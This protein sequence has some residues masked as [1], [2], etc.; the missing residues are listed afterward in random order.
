VQLALVAFPA[1]I[2]TTRA[3]SF[4]SSGSAHVV[5]VAVVAFLYRTLVSNPATIAF[6]PAT[7]SIEDG[8]ALIVTKGCV[9]CLSKLQWLE[10]PSAS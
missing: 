7:S 6:T 1:I 9:A 10:P 3:I 4:G 8:G 5:A 2:T